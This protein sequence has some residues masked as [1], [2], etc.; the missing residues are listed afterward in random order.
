MVALRWLVAEGSRTCRDRLDDVVIARTTA[1]VALELLPNRRFVRLPEAL[2]NIHSHHHHPG[3]AVA[4]LKRMM[5]PEGRLHG[6]KGGTGRCQPLDGGDRCA[7][8]L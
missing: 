1:D 3:G 6:V 7:F 8:A 4:A 2:R 5:L